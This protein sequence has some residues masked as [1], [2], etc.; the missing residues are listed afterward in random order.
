MNMY[1][2]YVT[3]NL[4]EK[5]FNIVCLVSPMAMRGFIGFF[6]FYSRIFNKAMAFIYKTI[7]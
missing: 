5:V 6:W 4:R 3:S 1:M 7:F 2:V